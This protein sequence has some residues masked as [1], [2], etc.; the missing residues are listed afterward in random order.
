MAW[1]KDVTGDE[2]YR[3]CLLGRLEE[4]MPEVRESCKLTKQKRK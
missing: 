1:V 4:F 2:R 3:V